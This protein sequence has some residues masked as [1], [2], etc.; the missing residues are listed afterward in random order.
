MARS[1]YHSNTR[2]RILEVAVR[3]FSESGYEGTS[4]RT[5]V[6]QAGTN[7]ASVNYHFG[8]K[9]ALYEAVLKSVFAALSDDI[10]ECIG[11]E[12]CDDLIGDPIRTF[13][14]RRILKGFHVHK[15][16]PPRLLGWEIISGRLTGKNILEERM[17]VM[18]ECMTSFLTPLFPPEITPSQK[19][20]LAR[21]FLAATMPPPPVIH[22][23]RD[24]LGNSPDQIELERIA[25]PLADAA[26]GGLK[27]MIDALAKAN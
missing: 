4:I 26:V 19:F 13:A 12:G 3:A 23:I 1:E 5:I 16:G 17:T 20:L 15:D 21:W 2:Q 6:A 9:K 14:L 11:L 10:D 27:A 24:K 7:I 8:G 22:A 18:E 25:G